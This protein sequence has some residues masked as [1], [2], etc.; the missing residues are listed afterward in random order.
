MGTPQSKHAEICSFVYLRTQPNKA[1]EVADHGVQDSHRL[2]EI[3][4]RRYEERITIWFCPSAL[5]EHCMFFKSCRLIIAL[6]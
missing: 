6:L 1:L 4:I 2:S 5:Y 3:A